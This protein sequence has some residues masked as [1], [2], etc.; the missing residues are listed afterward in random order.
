MAMLTI[1][2]ANVTSS[3]TATNGIQ[4]IVVQAG[5]TITGGMP[6]YKRLSGTGA[7]QWFQ[8][9]ADPVD[10]VNGGL[11]E[12]GVGLDLTT[13]TGISLGGGTA[14]VFFAVQT[15]GPITI[16]ATMTKGA[17]YYLS[18]TVGRIGD[19]ADLSSGNYIVDFGYAT[20]TT[21]LQLSVTI[22]GTV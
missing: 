14:G 15:T 13:Q 9:Q 18:A 10:G 12:A 4:K 16:G 5:E 22:L 8:M 7:G 11:A 2:A 6:V 21:V 19:L 17:H 3:L 1:T 20:S